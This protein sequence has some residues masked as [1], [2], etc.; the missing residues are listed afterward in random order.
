MQS[1]VPDPKADYRSVADALNKIVRNEGIKNTV[2]GFSAMALGAG[3]AHALYFACYEKMKF[4]L[5]DGKQGNH[6]AHGNYL[7]V[8]I[9]CTRYSY[10]YISMVWAAVYLTTA[11]FFLKPPK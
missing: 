3:P 5:S 6:F 1:L 2:R 7:Y 8:V 10:M 11:F 9:S 4:I